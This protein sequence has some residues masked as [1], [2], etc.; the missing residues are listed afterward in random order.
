MNSTPEAAHKAEIAFEDQSQL[1]NLFGAYDRHLA[2]L[3]KEFGVH[4]ASRGAQVA[5]SGP[6]E[7]VAAAENALTA[8][9]AEAQAGHEID[10]GRVRA[11]ARAARFGD[12]VT[13]TSIDTYKRPISPRRGPQARYV[14]TL[15]QS[16]LTFAV[17]PAGTGKTFLAVAVAVEM[18]KKRQVERIILSRPAVEAGE[19]LGFLPGDLREKVDPYLRPL[20]D[21]LVMMMPPE[22]VERR[23][24]NEEIEAAPLAFMRGRTLSNAFIILDEAQNTTPMQMKMALTRI[25]QGSRMVVTGDPSQT[26]LPDNQRSGL[27]DALDILP[28]IDDISV[29]KFTAK[30]VVREDLVAAIVTAYDTRARGYSDN[31]RKR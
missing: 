13:D 27:T 16:K 3:E 9:Y 15:R 6:A 12:D 5:I 7:A 8:L 17:G 10:D 21:A 19:K 31:V 11:A 4:L 22:M 24:A 18:M 29:A 2:R 23:L 30:D 28:G 25:G 20:K 1:S 26:D 14:E